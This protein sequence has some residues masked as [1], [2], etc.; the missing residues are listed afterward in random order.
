M[1]RLGTPPR[2]RAERREGR[3]ACIGRVQAPDPFGYRSPMKNDEKGAPVNTRILAG[4][5]ACLFA[6]GCASTGPSSGPSS[7]AKPPARSD[8]AT[9]GI[10]GK[11]LTPHLRRALKIPEGV[12]GV[13]VSEV[14]P[15]GPA[16][17]AGIRPNDVVEEIGNSRIRNACELVDA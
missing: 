3:D 4:L 16:A 15:G 9:L 6:A 5:A 8:R 11:S 7:S 13:L 14:F 2:K 12:S 17:D 10:E 1:R